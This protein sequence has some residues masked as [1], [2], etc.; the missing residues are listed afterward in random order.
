MK[1]EPARQWSPPS[2]VSITLERLIG[3]VTIAQGGVLLLR[4]EKK[5][6]APWLI[7]V[8]SWFTLCKYVICT[9]CEHHGEYC[10]F[11]GLGKPAA[12]MF[13]VKRKSSLS[14]FGWL[15]E[16]IS[17]AGMLVLP[18]STLKKSS[19]KGTLIY[20]VSVLAS[21]TSMFMISCRHCAQTA[22]DQW[23]S[24]CPNYRIAAGIWR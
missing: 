9:H 20:T 1:V 6:L 7:S 22:T 8:T 5:L 14:P 4:H 21:Y 10:E 2:R 11:Y 12:K 18:L 3:V 15:T 13:P 23:K 17:M 19:P 16:G 24:L